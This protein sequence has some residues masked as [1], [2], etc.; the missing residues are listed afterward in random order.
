MIFAKMVETASTIT[1]IIC[2]KNFL[3]R[4]ITLLFLSLESDGFGASLMSLFNIFT[5]KWYAMDT[6]F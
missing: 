1:L 4:L 6:L 2:K 3:I 5:P